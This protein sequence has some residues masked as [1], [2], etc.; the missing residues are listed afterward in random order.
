MKRTLLFILSAL[1]SI[2]S[3]A[4][5]ADD[6]LVSEPT[7]QHTT[8]S[9]VKTPKKLSDYQIVDEKHFMA[10]D[11]ITYEQGNCQQHAANNNNMC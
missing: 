2:T 3:C 11:N 9:L 4:N 1:F 10:G 5:K 6:K 7:Q 8:S